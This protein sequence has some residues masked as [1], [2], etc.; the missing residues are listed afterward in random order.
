MVASSPGIRYEVSDSRDRAHALTLASER[1]PYADVYP[2]AENS[3]REYTAAASPSSSSFA[4]ERGAIRR[5]A[6]QRRL[7]HW[8]G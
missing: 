7:N 3:A 1:S 4:F 8:L 6:L 5:R 2:D